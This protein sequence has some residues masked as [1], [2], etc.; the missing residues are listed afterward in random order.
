MARI[1]KTQ[2]EINLATDVLFKVLVDTAIVY[3]QGEERAIEQ[4]TDRAIDYIKLMEIKNPKLSRDEVK[5]MAIRMVE[6]N[7]H[8]IYK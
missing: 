2:K 8:R 3:I 1:T 5:S 7:R 6:Q 4:A